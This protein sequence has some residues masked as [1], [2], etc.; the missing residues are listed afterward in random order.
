[1]TSP[2]PILLDGGPFAIATHGLR[3]SYGSLHALDGVDLQVPEGSVYVLVGPN[4]AGKTTLLKTL[5]DLVR[6]REGRAEVLGLDPVAEG[7]RVRA[8]VGYVPERHDSVEAPLSVAAQLRYHAAFLVR[9]DAAY[10]AELLRVLE[11]D[12][13]R[14][15]NGL[16]KGE[17][18]RVQLILALAHRPPLLLLDEPTDGLDPLMRDTVLEVLAAHLAE[19]PTTVVLATHHASEVER[20]VDHVGVLRDGRLT[21]QLPLHEL[22]R[23]LLR[24]RAEV[25]AGWQ[26]VPGLNGAVLQ[27]AG[28]GRE[29]RWTVWGDEIE[30]L[31]HL[32]ASGAMVREAAPVH[33]DDAVLALLGKEK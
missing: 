33:L 29:I 21:A 9:W 13:G 17:V 28:G 6:A 12:P 7:P 5:L 11:V 18:R 4:G 14:P 8:Q 22:K 26:G 20:L 2:L 31:A 30:T 25:P 32:A 19:T 1:M 16:S 3:K 23:K 10:A 27:R 24:Y 15:L